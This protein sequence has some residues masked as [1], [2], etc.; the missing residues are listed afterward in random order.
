MHPLCRLSAALN[1]PA[2]SHPSACP[3]RRR[4]VPLN[5]RANF[6]TL[7]DLL[8]A[9]THRT[10]PPPHTQGALCICHGCSSRGTMS[11]IVSWWCSPLHTTTKTAA[12]IP[13]HRGTKVCAKQMGFQRPLTLPC[14][15][16]MLARPCMLQQEI[17][18]NF[19]Y[20]DVKQVS[21]WFIFTEKK[22]AWSVTEVDS[23]KD[24]YNIC[25]QGV[26]KLFSKAS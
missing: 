11:L 23:E 13:K 6:S 7:E 2:V 12:R 3:P 14:P 24:F 1:Y 8:R 19:E 15:Y 5:A 10:P 20:A 18:L 4:C 26:V 17:P 22:G 25:P 9:H 16:F 21:E